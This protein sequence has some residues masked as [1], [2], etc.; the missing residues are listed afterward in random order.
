[1]INLHR[2]DI[3]TLIEPRVYGSHA[4]E[5]CLKVGFANWIRVEVVGFSGGIW[6][7]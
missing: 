5:I 3:L 1:M 7:F 6:I 2:L 4:N